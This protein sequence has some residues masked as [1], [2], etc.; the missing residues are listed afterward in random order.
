M[1]QKPYTFKFV[2]HAF[3]FATHRRSFSSEFRCRSSLRLH[4][5]QIRQHIP[6]ISD[7]TIWTVRYAPILLSS[8]LFQSDEKLLLS[9]D[10]I[11]VLL[12]FCS[13]FV[14]TRRNALLLFCFALLSFCQIHSTSQLRSIRFLFFFLFNLFLFLLNSSSCFEP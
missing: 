4:S 5:A 8:I 13:T 3:R 10:L 11:F 14:P 9:S 6:F 2:I 7:M 12:R 1:F